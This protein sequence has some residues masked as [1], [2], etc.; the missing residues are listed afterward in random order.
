MSLSPTEWVGKK[1]MQNIPLMHTSCEQHPV[2]YN[3]RD[4]TN[5]LDEV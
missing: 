5:V 2:E 4:L 3:I 1:H